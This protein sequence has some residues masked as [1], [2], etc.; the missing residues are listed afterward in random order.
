M[1]QTNDAK[2]KG[3]NSG[4]LIRLQFPRRPFDMARLCQNIIVSNQ[5]EHASG[6]GLERVLVLFPIDPD[7]SNPDTDCPLDRANVS[8]YDIKARAR[9]YTTATWV[10]TIKSIRSVTRGR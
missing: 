9:Y 6:M 10:R 4:K 8:N 1:K 2:T 3:Q 5:G 7:R